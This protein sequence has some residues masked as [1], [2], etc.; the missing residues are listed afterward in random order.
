MSQEGM[1]LKM[2]LRI[3]FSK[4]WNGFSWQKVGFTLGGVTEHMITEPSFSIKL[5][6]ILNRLSNRKFLEIGSAFGSS[7]LITFT[8]Y[9][10]FRQVT[11]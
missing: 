2:V 9:Y 11:N 3:Q 10:Y 1:I 4:S 7:S 8:K 5:A 6:E